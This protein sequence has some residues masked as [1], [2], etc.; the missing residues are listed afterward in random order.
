[1]ELGEI[2]L[3]FLFRWDSQSDG[4]YHSCFFFFFVV[5]LWAGGVGGMLRLERCRDLMN[6]WQ[7]SL[8]YHS[9]NWN[10]DQT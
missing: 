1:M 4:L 6:E 5:Y 10:A 3:S 7:C 2:V 8:W 9:R